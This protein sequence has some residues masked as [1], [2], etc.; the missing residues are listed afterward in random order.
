MGYSGEEYKEKVINKFSDK[1]LL[2]IILTRPTKKLKHTEKDTFIE[3]T[4][5]T[6]DPLGNLVL[7]MDSHW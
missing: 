5:I 4:S 6:F 2:N 3:P 1:N 7:K